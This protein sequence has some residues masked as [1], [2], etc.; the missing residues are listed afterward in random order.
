M[1]LN[2]AVGI[3][4]G[5]DPITL[6]QYLWFKLRCHECS[7]TE[8]QRFFEQIIKK[9]SPD[10][11]AI[12]PYGSIG[13]RKCDG[14]FFSNGRI[15]QVYSPDE[16]T[17]ADLMRKINE[18]FDG[19]LSHWKRD[20]KHWTLVYNV[21]R[22]LPPD[23]PRLLIEKRKK[24]PRVVIDHFS[25]DDLWEMTRNLS[26]Q[27]RAEILGAPNGYE[28]LFLS[29]SSSVDEVREALDNACFVIVHDTMT[30]INPMSVT[31]ALL[32]YKPFGGMLYVNPIPGEPP[33]DEAAAYQREVILNAIE[34]SR[35]TLPRFAVFSLSHIALCIHLGFILSDRLEVLW[36][37]HDRD[38][39]S[40]K[41]AEDVPDADT[42]IK[43]SGLP[44]KMVEGKRE[45]IIRVSLSASISRK[46]T[47]NVVGG[48]PVEIDLSISDPDVMWLKSRDQLT[49]LGQKFR[50]VLK[51]VER[52]VTDCPRIHLFYAG[53][54]GGAI[55]L[56]QQINPRMHPPVELYEYSRHA[57]VQHQRVLTLR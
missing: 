33:W 34:R 48:R 36:F 32:P 25:N 21:R 24:H 3:P 31:E 9:S 10:F 57:T 27:K 11:M 49:I 12:R 54:T 26:L 18:D 1:N 2:A 46:A 35:G 16:L 52:N 44:K 40:W 43:V 55:V 8:F 20:M 19:A 45:V 29:P 23:I 50:N 7:P 37:Q 47:R 28:F 53:P 41:W 4:Q 42:N 5:Y 22:G 15:F 39:K 51:A 13:D 38:R 6:N 17:Q 14:L 30:P 56:G